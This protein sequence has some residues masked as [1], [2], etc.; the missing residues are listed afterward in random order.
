M[1]EADEGR[2]TVMAV[3]LMRE[4][5]EPPNAISERLPGYRTR[6]FNPRAVWDRKFKALNL[7]NQPYITSVKHYIGGP[8]Q[9]GQPLALIIVAPGDL[10]SALATITNTKASTA[11][12]SRGAPSGSHMKA[13]AA[14]QDG[15]ARLR[16]TPHG[17]YFGSMDD[18]STNGQR[19]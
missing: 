3:N 14:L 10:A 12:N 16:A 11:H 9:P 1:V 17:Y 15:L 5:P 18:V 6:V 19:C 4:I 7:A 13:A 2:D 8:V